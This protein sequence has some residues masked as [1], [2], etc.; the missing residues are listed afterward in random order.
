MSQR[1]GNLGIEFL[2]VFGLHPVEF[3]HLAADLGCRHIGIG[4]SP[5]PINPHRYAQIGRAHV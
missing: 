5:L 3:V 2:T 4:L 1:S